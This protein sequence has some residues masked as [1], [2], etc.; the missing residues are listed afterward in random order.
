MLETACL[1]IVVVHSAGTHGASVC[2]H[3][4]WIHQL[5]FRILSS[6]INDDGYCIVK[7]VT[8]LDYCDLWLPAHFSKMVQAI[9][10]VRLDILQRSYKPS[11]VLLWAGR[12]EFWYA[13]QP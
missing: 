8:S 10:V 12:Q 1:A 7:N 2:A 13:F 4:C 6:I 5:V 3:S 11:H 9:D